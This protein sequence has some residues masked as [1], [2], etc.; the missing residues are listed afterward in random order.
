LKRILWYF[1]RSII[2]EFIYIC[3]QIN[4]IWT[5]VE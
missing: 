5:L 4:Y 2:I 3:T 1:K